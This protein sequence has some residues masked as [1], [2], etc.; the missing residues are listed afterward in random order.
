M[1]QRYNV[2]HDTKKHDYNVNHFFKYAF[3]KQNL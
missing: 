2:M 1:L 3:I